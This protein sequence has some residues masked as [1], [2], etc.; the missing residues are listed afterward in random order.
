MKTKTK[1]QRFVFHDMSY[2]DF[3]NA[4]NQECIVIE[5]NTSLTNKKIL[6]GQLVE[7]NADDLAAETTARNAE[8]D[9][10]HKHERKTALMSFELTIFPDTTLSEQQQNDIKRV[11]QE[12]LN[13][14]TQANYPN[15]FVKPELNPTLF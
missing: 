12:W 15:D 6:N 5:K 2:Q 1:N 9:A 10:Q 8:L 14:T 7:K 13:I 4:T 3:P 11:R